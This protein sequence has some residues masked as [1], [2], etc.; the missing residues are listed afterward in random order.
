[1]VVNN[2][3]YT[4]ITLVLPH[5]AWVSGSKPLVGSR[6]NAGHRVKPGCLFLYF[7]NLLTVRVLGRMFELASPDE[8]LPRLTTNRLTE[9]FDS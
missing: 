8:Q 6:K 9:D 7:G 5:N 2:S 4:Q 1:M 3:Q